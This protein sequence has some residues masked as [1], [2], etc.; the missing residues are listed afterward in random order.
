[1]GS[2]RPETLLC[3]RPL[4]LVIP[5]FQTTCSLSKLFLNHFIRKRAF[6]ALNV[7][8]SILAVNRLVCIRLQHRRRRRGV[9]TIRVQWG[10][11]QRRP[12]FLRIDN[13]SFPLPNGQV[14]KVS[15]HT[16]WVSRLNISH[17]NGPK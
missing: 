1:M 16:R 3:I 11:L 12:V 13:T 7:G 9:S 10:M 4:I 5:L 8:A 2:L 6:S 15:L 14:R 17:G